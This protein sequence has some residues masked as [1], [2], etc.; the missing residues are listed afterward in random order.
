[1][2][3]RLLFSDRL[4]GDFMMLIPR[5]SRWPTVR[6]EQ[7]FQSLQQVFQQHRE[8]VV[9]A[10]L[11]MKLNLLWVSLKVRQGGC[12]E[13]VGAVREEIPEALLVASHAEVLQG[14][15]KQKQK[16]R[17]RFRLPFRHL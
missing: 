14:M 3:L 9:F 6:R 15:A 11:N 12:W 8:L 2:S 1:P 13:L 17:F 10:D 7:A 4:L 16:R 5:F